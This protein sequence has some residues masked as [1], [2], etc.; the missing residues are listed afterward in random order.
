[1]QPHQQRVVDERAELIERGEKLRAFMLS[2]AAKTLPA[3]EQDR[4][5]RQYRVMVQYG[6][7][8]RERIEAFKD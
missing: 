8:L 4:L 2:D 7:I 5:T 6:V 1:M 3:D